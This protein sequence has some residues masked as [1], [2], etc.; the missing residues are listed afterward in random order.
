[1]VDLSWD[2]L[3]PSF[4]VLFFVRISRLQARRNWVGVLYKQECVDHSLGHKRRATR[5]Q[6]VED[7]AERIDVAAFADETT[8]RGSLIR[9]HVVGRAEQSRMP[10]SLAAQTAAAAFSARL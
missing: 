4:A 6:V 9:R 3:R 10:P 8:M 5:Q 7:G 1:M 2:V